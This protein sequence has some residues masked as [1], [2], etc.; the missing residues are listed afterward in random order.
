MNRLEW[1]AGCISIAFLTGG[2][3][4]HA[5]SATSGLQVSVQVVRSCSVQTSGAATSIDCGRRMQAAERGTSA[6]KAIVQTAGT[7]STSGMTTINF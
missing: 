7:S 2:A 3:Q 6:P 4:V 5:D 1:I